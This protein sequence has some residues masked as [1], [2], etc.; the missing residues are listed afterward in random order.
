MA[1]FEARTSA[2][3]DRSVV[4][5]AGECDLAVRDELTSALMQAIESAPVVELDLDDLEFIDSTGVHVLVTAY[6]AAQREGTSFYVVN[7]HGPV[8]HV[9]DITGVGDL[10]RAPI[11]GA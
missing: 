11:H 9:L 5:L 7:A 10:L 6:H 4:A 3:P 1:S 8:E 2:H